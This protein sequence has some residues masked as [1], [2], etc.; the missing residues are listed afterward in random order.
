MDTSKAPAIAVVLGS[1][2]L[3]VASWLPNKE[4]SKVV[5]DPLK[6]TLLVCIHEKQ[7]PTIDEVIAVRTAKDFA[8]ANGFKGWLV[9]DKDDPN[10]QSVVAAA[11]SRQIEPPLLAAG[12]VANGKLTTLIKIVKWKNGLEDILK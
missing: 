3:L 12:E 4:S 6:G 2:L 9:I 1:I 8:T 5:N 11:A 10:W 7:N